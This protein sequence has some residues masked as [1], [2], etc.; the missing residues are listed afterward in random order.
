MPRKNQGSESG[1]MGIFSCRYFPQNVIL[2][3]VRWYCRYG[4]SYRDL[5]EMM[6]ERGV[7]VDHTAIYRWVQKYDP[8]LDKRTH[9]YRK[10]SL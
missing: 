8:E 7:A 3:A 6:T 4:V 1:F 10:T 2:Q 9:W 5:E